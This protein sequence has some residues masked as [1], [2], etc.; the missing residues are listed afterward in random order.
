MRNALWIGLLILLSTGTPANEVHVLALR[1]I[2]DQ[3]S[4]VIAD[5]E[6]WAE[7]DIDDSDC[8]EEGDGTDPEDQAQSRVKNN[9]CAG[10][11]L[12][13]SPADP[14]RV[15][16]HSL[17]RLEAIALD[18][19]NTLGLTVKQVPTDRGP[20]QKGLHT[21]TDGKTVGEGSLVVYVG[22]LLESHFASKESVNCHRARNA[23]FDIHMAFS[24]Q[25]PPAKP[26][27]TKAEELECGSITAE[28]IPR[29]RPEDWH[30]LGNL[31]K[32]GKTTSLTNA[33]TKITGWDLNRPLRIT[34][35]LFFDASHL[36]CDKGKKLGGQPPRASNWEIHPVYAIDVCSNTS[37]AGCAFD[38][39][40]VWMPLH[41]WIVKDEEDENDGTPVLNSSQH[42]PMTARR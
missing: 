3:P 19:R 5:Q 21:T 14:A 36:T 27:K 15:T 24:D 28:V 39:K 12:T 13:S 10:S 9:L 16:H 33:Q 6:F 41:E 40:D 31:S 7:T 4:C 18:L 29:R 17:K 26:S 42:P 37:L 2:A 1:P 30:F 35:Q 25:K 38:R 32:K 23:N 22:F 34:G 11:F 8:G 20:F